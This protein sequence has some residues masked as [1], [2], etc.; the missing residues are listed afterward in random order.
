MSAG[1]RSRRPGKVVLL[2]L[3][4]WLAG[5]LLQTALGWVL[6]TSGLL[7][8]GSALL[9]SRIVAWGLLCILSFVYREPL[10]AWLRT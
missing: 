3:A 10:D 9:A 6:G 2:V 8:Q 4:F 7:D 5:S 1:P